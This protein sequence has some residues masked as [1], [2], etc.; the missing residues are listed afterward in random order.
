MPKGKPSY[1]MHKASGQAVMTVRG[2]T[3]YLGK[4]GS[5]ESHKRFSEI[6]A[7]HKLG[8]PI[9]SDAGGLTVAEAALAYLD[10]A[11]RY[12]RNQDGQSTRQTPRIQRALSTLVKLHAEERL[13]TIGPKHV[14]ELLEKWVN[15]GLSRQYA[16]HLLVV[17]KTA[18]KW[19]A[20]E[21][22]YPA[23]KFIE[24]SLVEGLKLGRTRAREC[25]PTTA[26]PDEDLVATLPH[27]QPLI[28][29]MVQVQLLTGC[30][31]GELV[32]MT[33]K[34][35]DRENWVYHPAR[36]KNLWRGHARVIHLGPQAQEI[37]SRHICA[38][39][40]L[41]IFRV[42]RQRHGYTVQAYG[43]NIARVCKRIGV[44]PW[45]PGQLRH[46]AAERILGEIGWDAA[47]AVLGHRSVSTT[48]IYADRDDRTASDAAK[49]LG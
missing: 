38:N 2:Q 41:P 29:D 42:R 25:L 30:R 12:Y 24:I 22:Y 3:I 27:L 21:G 47:R 44:I 40:D 31:P 8:K 33:W 4:F 11:D 26:V 32:A 48:R 14:R 39:P 28:R 49:K 9:I 10:F 34:Q 15:E 37:L 45:S 6:L 23:H 19:L 36:H 46:N 20:R 16:N 17:V 5:P 43:R 13:D 1:R 18:F 35:I 7:D